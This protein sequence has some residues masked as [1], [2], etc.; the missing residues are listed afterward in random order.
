MSEISALQHALNGVYKGMQGLRKNAQEIASNSDTGAAT[1][2]TRSV[3]ELIQNRNQVQASAKVIKTVDD[4]LGVL[5]DEK[6]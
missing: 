2:L 4:T 6:A 3:V 1:D 5:L